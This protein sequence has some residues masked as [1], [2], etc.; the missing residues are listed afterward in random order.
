MT[1]TYAISEDR[2]NDVVEISITRFRCS[3]QT[4]QQHEKFGGQLYLKIT[5][6]ENEDL[7][8]KMK[9]DRFEPTIALKLEANNA[10]L[11]ATVNNYN[12][13]QVKILVRLICKNFIGKKVVVGKIEIDRHSELWKEI[14]GKPSVPI[15]RMVNFE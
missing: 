1:L 15:T 4:M 13:D 10:T 5:A 8:Q 3:L 11:R 9:S 12:L 14:V 2:K 6:F 7:I